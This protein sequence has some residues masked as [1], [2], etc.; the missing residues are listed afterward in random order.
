M[1][2]IKKIGRFC[3][4]DDQGFII[5]DA[6]LNKIQPVFWEV[7]QEIKDTCCQLLRDDLHSVYIRGSIPRGIGIEGIADVDMIILVQKDPKAINLSWR[8]KLEV[9]IT[10]QFTCISG[11]ELSFY[12]EKEVINSEDFSFIGFMIQTH[13]VCILGEDVK[14]FL[15]KYKVSQE[16]AYEHLIHLRK[17]IE[18]A[19]KELIHNQDVDDIEDCCRWI[20]K[21]IIRAGLALTIDRE[22]LYSRDLYPAYAL[23]SKHFSEQK[24]N[25]RKALQYVIE[26]IK[27]IE[28][29]L[30]FLD[31]FG[32]W[33]IER[34]G[35]YL[36]NIRF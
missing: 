27:D 21:I 14:L 11:V 26:P 1:P 9:Q 30:S 5:N 23:F 8:K 13:S 17:Q 22:G 32:N 4:V 20:M 19:H 12:S 6:H 28:E 29:I 16:I 34:A 31:T 10:Q 3:P 15:P 24:K 2:R 36:K 35:D 33:L 7:I 18:Q 25:M